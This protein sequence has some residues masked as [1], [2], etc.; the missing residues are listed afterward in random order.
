[1]D[2]TFD[3][4]WGDVR[5]MYE[6]DSDAGVFHVDEHGEREIGFGAF[7]QVYNSRM[8][9]E[10]RKHRMEV[11]TAFEKLDTDH[12]GTLSREKVDKLVKSTKKLLKLLPPE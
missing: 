8:G 3:S 10:R 9:A 4:L 1:M 6:G 12:S 2:W 11:K 7:V 5:R